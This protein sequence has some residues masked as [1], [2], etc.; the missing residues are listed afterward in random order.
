MRLR[1]P[2]IGSW[3]QLRDSTV[4]LVP[5]SATLRSGDALLRN[6]SKQTLCDVV[7]PDFGKPHEFQYP[8][9]AVS[10]EVNDPFRKSPPHAVDEV[11]QSNS[12]LQS[13]GAGGRSLFIT[14]ELQRRRG[15][16]Q[17]SGRAVP[18]R[19]PFSPCRAEFLIKQP[20]CPD[21]DR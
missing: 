15:A 4:A 13:D 14:R 2:G 7:Y 1:I 6:T 9:G 10:R 16:F 17:R 20:F 3:A 18:A 5:K 11:R 21:V 8:V 19:L 12:H